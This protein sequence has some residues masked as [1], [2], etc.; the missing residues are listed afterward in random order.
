METV[1]NP[2]II[3][4]YM[5]DNKITEKEFCKECNIPLTSLCKIINCDSEVAFLHFLRVRYLL[6]IK[7]YLPRTTNA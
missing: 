1:I 6:R 2:Q 3:K 7:G 4:Q 5:E